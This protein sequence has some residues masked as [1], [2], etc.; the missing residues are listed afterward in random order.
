MLVNL[1]TKYGVVPKTLYSESAHSVNTRL[2]NWIVT[3]K[4]REYAGTLR[5]AHKAGKDTA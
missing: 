5:Q 1:F 4:L 2:L 3:N